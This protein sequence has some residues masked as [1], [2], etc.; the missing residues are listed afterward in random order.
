MKAFDPKNRPFTALRLIETMKIVSYVLSLCTINGS[1]W[2]PPASASSA[3]LNP[4]SPFLSVLH[5]PSWY[6]DLISLNMFVYP[7]LK[8][9]DRVV[10]IGTSNADT[11]YWHFYVSAFILIC[12]IGGL[13]N[14]ASSFVVDQIVYGMKGSIAASL[15]YILAIAPKKIL[16]EWMDIQ[17]NANDILFGVFII[18]LGSSIFGPSPGTGNWKI[19]EAAAWGFGGLAGNMFG[20]YQ[21][22]KYGIGWIP[23]W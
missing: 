12:I 8:I 13:S 1:H 21:V 9:L 14:L 17:T 5:Q 22:E 10:S 18:A 19:C 11:A 16:S 23:L 2:C 7:A 3:I 6:T 4:I 15:G 20:K